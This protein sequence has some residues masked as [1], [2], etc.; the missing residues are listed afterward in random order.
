MVRRKRKQTTQPVVA[1]DDSVDG[2]LSRIYTN[3]ADPGSFRTANALHRRA[4]ALGHTN[5][6]REHVI[7]ILAKQNPHTLHRQA[8]RHFSRV[9]IYAHEIDQQWQA[10][11][12]D[13]NKCVDWNEN[14]RYILVV[15]VTL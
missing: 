8:R 6:T 3:P 7:H 5:I 4:R 13:M 1:E 9:P 14:V 11:L 10:D 2:V 15:V 12:A